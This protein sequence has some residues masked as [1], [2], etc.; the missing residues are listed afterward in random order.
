[1]KGGNERQEAAVNSGCVYDAQ[2]KLCIRRADAVASL[3]NAAVYNGR[4][5]VTPGMVEPFPVE[6]NA[7]CAR[8]DGSF[9]TDN[10][11][12]D[13]AFFVRPDNEKG[14]LFCIEVQ[15]SQEPD[16]PVRIHEYNTRDL[17]RLSREPE[18]ASSHRLPPIVPLLLNFSDSR[19][20][21]P[22]SLLDMAEYRDECV[23]KV[24][25]QGRFIL[26]D[27]YDMDGKMLSGLCT[28]LKVVLSCF[29]VSR[30]RDKLDAV[31]DKYRHERLSI[32]ALR[33]L[34]VFFDVKM[35]I[36]GDAKEGEL[37]VMCEAIRQMR[38]ESYNEGHNKGRS[39]GLIQGRS[40]GLIQ[41]RSEGLSQGRSEGLSQGLA[42]EKENVTV[43][44]LRRKM[45]YDDIQAITGLSLERIASIARSI[46]TTQ[47]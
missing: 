32:E 15:T 21:S 4:Q 20:R 3:C 27:P 18:Y 39:E 7:V 23:D 31:L 22:C 30:D 13:L 42:K 1:M 44:A 8:G 16:M 25:D 5:I 28:D 47:A 37:G 6:Q 9:T 12:R 10:R 14:F 34:E 19:W 29:P 35:K 43:N 24:A 38:E 26:V 17:L 33:F 11:F 36:A 41:G 46:G 2:A 40:E 45:S